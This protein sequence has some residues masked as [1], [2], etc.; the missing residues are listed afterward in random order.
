MTYDCVDVKIVFRVVL[1][2]PTT[3]VSDS[4]ES[5]TYVSSKGSG[6]VA[7]GFLRK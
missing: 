7:P 6:I 4:I 1:G 5:Y 3:L 2:F